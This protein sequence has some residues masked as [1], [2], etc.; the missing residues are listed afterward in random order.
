M[1]GEASTL[2]CPEAVQR[3]HY[4]PDGPRGTWKK[5]GPKLSPVGRVLAALLVECLKLSSSSACGSV[6]AWMIKILGVMASTA[7]TWCGSTFAIPE[8]GKQRQEHQEFKG[9]LGYK[10]FTEDCL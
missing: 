6:I 9:T 8:L 3:S 4:Y 2:I 5:S 7:Y 10:F 1:Q